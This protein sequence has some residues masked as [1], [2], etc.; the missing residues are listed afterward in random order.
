MATTMTP[1]TTP[2]TTPPTRNRYSIANTLAPRARPTHRAERASGV[3]SAP[4]GGGTFGLA[5][6]RERLDHPRRARD[7][8]VPV[9]ELRHPRGRPP[10]RERPV[11]VTDRA[12]EHRTDDPLRRLDVVGT[13]VQLR[14]D[15]RREIGRREDGVERSVLRTEQRR[16]LLADAANA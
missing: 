7:D 2:M 8:A 16:G 6:R 3:R 9:R 1:S 15:R 4:T 10:V 11:H 13:G 14:A 12:V 5:E